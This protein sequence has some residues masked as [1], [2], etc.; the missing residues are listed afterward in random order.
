MARDPKNFKN[1]TQL[2][3]TA[4]DIIDAVASSTKSVVRKLSFYNSGTSDRSVTVYVVASGGTAGTTNTLAVKSIPP[5]KT[6]NVIEA[7]GEILET[8]MKLQASQDAGAD[9]NANCSG[10]NIT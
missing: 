2:S 4:V 6:W 3:T 5:K 10:A 7:Q 8:G 1:T 9:I